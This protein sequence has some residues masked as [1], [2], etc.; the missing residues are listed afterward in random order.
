MEYNKRLYESLEAIEQKYNDLNQQ[1]ETAHIPLEQLKDINRQ[2]KRN[3]P[4]VEL[5]R[6]YK[7]AIKNAM[8]S[9]KALN[10]NSLDGEL[11]ELAKM[12]LEEIKTKIPLQEEKFKLL[13]LPVDP[14]N[15]K[16][17]IIEMRPAAGGDEASIFVADL[18]DTYKRYADKQN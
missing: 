4:I 16:N 6:E 11:A 17:V 10:N 2:L 13:L 12:E 9:E 15:D 8:D 3:K 7:V 14:N 18:F 1:L 5:F